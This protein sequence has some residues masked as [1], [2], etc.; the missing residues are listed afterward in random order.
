ML[1]PARNRQNEY[2]KSDTSSFALQS[3]HSAGRAKHCAARRSDP[4]IIQGAMLLPYMR[5]PALLTTKTEQ[6]KPQS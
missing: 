6:G 1:R 4:S 5:T 3:L 2:P